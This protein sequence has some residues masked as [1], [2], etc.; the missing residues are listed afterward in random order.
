MGKNSVILF[1]SFLLYIFF[2]CTE[3]SFNGAEAIGV[4]YGRVG[5]NLPPPVEVAAMYTSNKIGEMRIYDADQEALQAFQNT[6]IQ[7]TVG[8][9]NENLPSIASSQDTANQWVAAN[10][11]PHYPKI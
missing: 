8:V 1:I 9:P 7:V 3:L 11:Q 4:C 6:S 5:D 2:F 10:I